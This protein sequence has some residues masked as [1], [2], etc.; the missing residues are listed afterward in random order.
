MA[1][2]KIHY[3]DQ[4]LYVNAG[5]RFPACY[6]GAALLDL[7]KGR[8]MTTGDP[9]CIECHTCRRIYRR[10]HPG[11]G[12]NMAIEGEQGKGRDHAN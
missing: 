8:L 12:I 2:G 3:R 11:R 5:M 1:G 10:V 9:A 6:A 4:R 7:D